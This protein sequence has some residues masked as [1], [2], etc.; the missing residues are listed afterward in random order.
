M[1]IDD[2]KI[3]LNSSNGSGTNNNS[4]SYNFD[5]TP[6]KSGF[7]EM[8]FNF[9]SGDNAVD[10][11]IPA[12]LLINF[13]GSK[14]YTTQSGYTSATS[15]NHVGILY[16]Y[17]LS[18]NQGYLK[19][20]FEDNSPSVLY[21]PQTNTFTVTVNSIVSTYCSFTGSIAASSTTLTV[22]A[23]TTGTLSVGDIISGTGIYAGTYISGYLTGVGGTGTYTLNQTQS[24][25]VNSETMTT[26]NLAGAWVDNQ[27]QQLSSYLLVLKFRKI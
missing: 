11:A 15:T 13:G 1:S 26:G 18:V 20:S 24:A 5:F 9:V 12:E 23:V 3:V 7:Y 8:T 2:F 17:Y 25:V 27:G 4:L 21:R 6:F 10:P 19:A 16:P 22:T 14:N